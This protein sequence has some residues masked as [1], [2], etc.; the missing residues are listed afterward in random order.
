M[1]KTTNINPRNSTGTITLTLDTR[2]AMRG[3]YALLALSEQ[4]T[5]AG[6]G[7][8]DESVSEIFALARAIV[9]GILVEDAVHLSV[10]NIKGLAV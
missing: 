8:T 1:E 5:K 3:L 9:E 10:T 4:D 7:I 2:D 6:S